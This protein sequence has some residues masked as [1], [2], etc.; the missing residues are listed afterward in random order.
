MYKGLI[1]WHPI[2][3]RISTDKLNYDIPTSSSL[4]IYEN[5]YDR[6]QKELLR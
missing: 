5:S 2:Y 6:K 4:T 3:K 1:W